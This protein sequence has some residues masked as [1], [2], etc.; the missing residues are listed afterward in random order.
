MDMEIA[1]KLQGNKDEVSDSTTSL[2]GIHV[3]LI[4]DSNS[5][6]IPDSPQH[7][8]IE[9]TA[10]QHNSLNPMD[11]VH[12]YPLF[13]KKLLD[14]TIVCPPGIEKT[15]RVNWSRI[16]AAFPLGMSNKAPGP[17]R[18]MALEMENEDKMEMRQY[19]LPILLGGIGFACLLL[20]LR[21]V[22]IKVHF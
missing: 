14:G 2:G 9:Y 6:S 7:A 17:V 15:Y 10:E 19:Y 16:D 22:L 8:I 20:L 13:Q 12:T 4:L 18:E 1:R 5:W 3:D 11:Q 21:V